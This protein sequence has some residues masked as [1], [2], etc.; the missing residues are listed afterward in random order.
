ML[1][2]QLSSCKILRSVSTS[3]P[4]N[5]SAREVVSGSRMCDLGPKMAQNGSKSFFL[6][7]YC[8]FQCCVSTGRPSI[9][10]LKTWWPHIGHIGQ[11]RDAN[12]AV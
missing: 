10:V 6:S 1:Q 7:P 9:S 4:D 5:K 3:H 11:A 12:G 8:T 2:S